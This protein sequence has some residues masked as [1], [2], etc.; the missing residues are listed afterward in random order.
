MQLSAFAGRGTSKHNLA[1]Y[2]YNLSCLIHSSQ[3]FS[4]LLSKIFYE[5]L[6]YFYPHVLNVFTKSSQCILL[7][8]LIGLTISSSFHELLEKFVIVFE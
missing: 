8:G 6:E 2:F 5:K 3:Y 7:F 1:V 4:Q